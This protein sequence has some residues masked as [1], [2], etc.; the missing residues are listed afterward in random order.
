MCLSQSSDFLRESALNTG[1][2]PSEV[3]FW[4]VSDFPLEAL[5]PREGSGTDTGTAFILET[6][7]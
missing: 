5:T 4:Q 2:T 7:G 3:S 6:A 1:L